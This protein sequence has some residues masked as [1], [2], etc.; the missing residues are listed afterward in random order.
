MAE[1]KPISYSQIAERNLLNPLITEVEEL[2]KSLKVTEGNLKVIISESSKLANSTPLNS[3]ENIQKVE[4]AISDSTMAV[5]ELDKVQKER[6]SLESKLKSLEDQRVKTNFELKEQIR[7]QTKALRENAKEAVNSKNAYE[8]L[9]DEKKEARKELLRLT[10]T[11]GKNS[12]EVKEAKERF[13]SLDSQI[14]EINESVKREKGAFELLND[15]LKQAKINAQNV[16]TQFGATSKEAEKAT[17]EYLQL[18]NEVKEV[19][20]SLKEPIDTDEFKRLTRSVN[21][22]Q[23]EYKIL[24]ATF[25]VSSKEAK[26]ALKNFKALDDELSE[27]NKNARDGRRDV[28]RYEKGVKGLN[29]AFKAFASATIVLK[30][31]ELTRDSF[32]KNSDSAAEFAKII[33]RV[34]SVIEVFTRRAVEGFPIITNTIDKFF[35]ETRKDFLEFRRDIT[36]IGDSL[37]G[38]FG[39]KP[40]GTNELNKSIDELDENIKKLS[41][42]EGDLLKLFSGVGK[43][44]EDLTKRNI[45]L[46]DNTLRYRK[47]IIALEKEIADLIPTTEKLRSSFEDDS[48]SLEDQIKAGIEFRKELQLRFDL[49][50][51]IAAKRLKLAQDNA[52]VNKTNVEAQEE[53]SAATLEYNQLIADQATELATTEKE[54]QKLR[55]DATQLNLDFYIDDFDNRK[56][57]NER[58]IADETQTFE[59]RRELLEQNRVET[60]KANDLRAEA[61]NKSL[62]ER[63]QAEL[64]FEELRKKN[65]SEEIARAVRESGLSEQLAVRALEIIRERRTELQDNAEAQRDLNVAEAESRLIQ[66]DVILQQQALNKLQ[67]EGVDIQMVLSELSKQRLQNEI[68]SLQERLILAKKG[69]EEFIS[70][71]QEL[72]DKLLE[73]DQERLDQE[74]KNQEERKKG[75]EELSGAANEGFQILTD[76]ARKTSDER[77]RQIDDE[78]K[79]EESRVNKLQ[80]LANQGNEDAEDNLAKSEQRQAELELKRQQ[81]LERQQRQELVF[82]AIQT[83]SSKVESGDPNPLAS[84]VSDISVLRAFINSLP[85]FFSGTED[86]GTVNS[87]IDNKGG[88]L[89]ILHNHERVIDQENN[90]LIGKMS[91]KELA[92]IANKERNKPQLVRDSSYLVAKEI[93]E[94]KD[95]TKNKPTYMGLDYD[96]IADAITRKIQKGKSLERIHSKNGG[97][98]G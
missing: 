26:D 38:F 71:S 93:K 33:A 67:E 86:T 60:E 47:E 23:K 51:E 45:E 50:E 65:S 53:L 16:A 80:E 55:D 14:N 27:I 13:E 81:Q 25:G 7:L 62:R 5:K 92:M 69:S 54:I 98:W 32:G 82:T 59:R 88:R 20:E 2:N 10:A 17:Q 73:Q 75:I 22:A 61:L 24:A 49:E 84:T 85:S 48:K 79:K 36:E 83:Y 52:I 34:T 64:D 95:I 9:V 70:I 8:K 4:K 18:K 56:T 57:V 37:R 77:T 58:I 89:A 29:A 31:L 28:G 91:N 66:N 35:K 96:A 94:L 42:N 43:E 19:N 76:I 72:N 87:S 21:E 40:K 30:V 39:I 1:S 90:K 74:K 3:F 63:G 12:D 97:I 78:I 44:I 11:F 6:I 15:E 68:D 41:E 46:I